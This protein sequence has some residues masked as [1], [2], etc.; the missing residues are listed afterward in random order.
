MSLLED[1]KTL[2]GT[3]QQQA[4]DAFQAS[5][6]KL[7]AYNTHISKATDEL[8]S[9]LL[10]KFDSFYT[11]MEQHSKEVTDLKTTIDYQATAIERLEKRVKSIETRDK[12]SQKFQVKNNLIIRSSEKST[13][14]GKFICNTIQSGSSDGKKPPANVFTLTEIKPRGK[15]NPHHPEATSH[16]GSQVG[17]RSRSIYRAVFKDFSHIRSFWKG[18]PTTNKAGSSTQI[19]SEMPQ[20]LK[21]LYSDFEKAA[22]TIRTTYSKEGMKTRIVTK[23]LSLRMQFKTR[24]DNDWLEASS[25]IIDDKIDIPVMFRDGEKVPNIHPTVRDVLKRADKH[26]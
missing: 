12:K 10:K 18:I 13:D 21:S 17:G 16:E 15:V 7:D 22:Y 9:G 23:N 14:I 1:I 25:P 4:R 2:C 8:M 20:Y 26:F 11:Q 19:S 6:G 3:F 5:G 24:T